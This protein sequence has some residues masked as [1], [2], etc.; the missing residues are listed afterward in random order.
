VIPGQGTVEASGFGE[1]NEAQE[2]G[3][4]EL[5]A[6]SMKADP[7][8][9]ALLRWDASEQSAMLASSTRSREGAGS[10]ARVSHV[11]GRSAMALQLYHRWHCPERVR[12]FIDQQKL[13]DQIEFIEIGEVKDAE[14]K[15]D[16]LTGGSQVPC[17]VIDGKPMLESRE[18]VQWL[19]ANL[20]E[21]GALPAPGPPP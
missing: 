17:L 18:I 1:L 4:R 3:R 21:S 19:Q 7:R 11:A 8:H 12:D 6:P 14:A 16:E 13:S 9:G 10:P 2:F 20:V 15:L 5:L